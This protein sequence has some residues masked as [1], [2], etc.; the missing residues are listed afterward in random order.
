MTRF[1][2]F[3]YLIGVGDI[4]V[5]P[6][7]YPLYSVDQL[8]SIYHSMASYERRNGGISPVLNPFCHPMVTRNFHPFA[9]TPGEIHSVSGLSSPVLW[10]KERVNVTSHDTGKADEVDNN[11]AN[12]FIFAPGL[13]VDAAAWKQFDPIE[14][15]SRLSLNIIAMELYKA[16]KAGAPP[17][18]LH[19]RSTSLITQASIASVYTGYAMT[20]DI[21]ENDTEWVRWDATANSDDVATLVGTGHGLV[22][23]FLLADY[24]TTIGGNV[25]PRFMNVPTHTAQ[26]Y[27]LEEKAKSGCDTCKT[28]MDR[29]GEAVVYATVRVPMLSEHL[30]VR[31]TPRRCLEFNADAIH[32]PYHRR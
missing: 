10:V 31:G 5:F 12:Q 2:P 16:F 9:V 24:K 28:V 1:P 27:V 11:L 26:L 21:D 23:T 20:A 8:L 7:F 3:T 29:F 13:M 15:N 19:F 30:L 25:I 22:S 14:E 4:I 18:D 17:T 32:H 6:H